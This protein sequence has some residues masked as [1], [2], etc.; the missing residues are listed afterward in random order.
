[1]HMTPP[2]SNMDSFTISSGFLHDKSEGRL[3]GLDAVN[4]AEILAV[5]P[6]EIR[7]MWFISAKEMDYAVFGRR[8][9][10]PAG[11]PLV[12]RDRAAR[13]RSHF[14][15][16][17]VEVPVVIRRFR[18]RG[19]ASTAAQPSRELHWAAQCPCRPPAGLAPEGLRIVGARMRRCCKLTLNSVR[20]A[21]SG[22]R[23]L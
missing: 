12:I 7:E 16:S 2:V 6:I 9:L 5:I 8:R 19:C 11:T 10:F 21:S 3:C 13:R 14:S 23:N 22:K 17:R 20:P 15:A 4:L 1:M 18:Q